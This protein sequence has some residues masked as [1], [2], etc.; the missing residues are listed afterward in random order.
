MLTQNSKYVFIEAST[1]GL[2]A[3]TSSHIILPWV[4]LETLG[5]PLGIFPGQ[6]YVFLD[7]NLWLSSYKLQ[8]DALEVVFAK[9]P[10][11]PS[12][13]QGQGNDYAPIQKH[14]FIPDDWAT[15]SS[16]DLCCM[17]ADE[18]LIYPRD[19]KVSLIKTNFNRPSF[20]HG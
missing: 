11:K 16:L 18:T 3:G 6:R 19:D 12:E 10:F 4:E 9:S 5:I 20:R 2:P 17:T 15:S 7:W 14:Y 1:N 13:D 8:D